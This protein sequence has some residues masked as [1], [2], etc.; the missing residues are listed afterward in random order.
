MFD[1]RHKL[2]LPPLVNAPRKHLWS[3]ISDFFDA[4]IERN[5]RRAGDYIQIGTEVLAVK[6]PRQI[7]VAVAALERAHIQRAPVVRFDGKTEWYATVKFLSVSGKLT[8]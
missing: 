4:V 1:A 6:E 3:R 2:A 7:K 5:N 8:E